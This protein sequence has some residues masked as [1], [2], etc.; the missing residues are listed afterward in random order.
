MIFSGL[1]PAMPLFITASAENKLDPSDAEYVDIIHTNAIV[2]GK[3]ER[4]GHADFY[5]NGGIIQP[6]CFNSETSNR[7]QPL[8]AGP[9]IFATNVSIELQTPFRA[10]IRGLRTTILSR[11]AARRDSGVGLAAPTLPTY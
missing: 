4:C 3:L 11:F 2:Q 6:G 5:M 9:F 8:M 1:D 10:A 7:A